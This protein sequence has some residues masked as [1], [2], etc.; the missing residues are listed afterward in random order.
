[1]NHTT[2]NGDDETRDFWNAMKAASLDLVW[3]TG[4]ANNNGFLEA[5]TTSST[6]NQATA[7]YSYIHQL[8][9]KNIFVDTSFGASMMADTWSSASAAVLN[10]RI[11]EGVIAVNVNPKPS[12]YQTSISAVASQ[13]AGTCAP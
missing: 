13:L 5:S 12:S 6:Y 1:M 4:V 7:R 8:T 2:W 3:T 9:G 11:A 10:Q